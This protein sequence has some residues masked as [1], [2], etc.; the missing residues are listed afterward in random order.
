[1]INETISRTIDAIPI[2]R[3]GPDDLSSSKAFQN[4]PMHFH[5]R[6]Y[7]K[8]GPIYRTWFRDRMWVTL[9]GLDAN[10]FVWRNSK[11]WSYGTA[12]APFH[13]EM[14]LDHVTALD[15]KEHLA[16]RAILK[17]AVNQGPATR[18][19]PQ[20]LEIL[21]RDLKEQSEKDEPME[22][23]TYWAEVIIWIATHTHVR[24]KIPKEEVPRLARWEYQ[25]LRGL[26]LDDQR[27]SYVERQE[28]KELKANAYKWMGMIVDE[29]LNAPDK[30]DDNFTGVIEARAKK[31]GEL[32]RDNLMNDLYLIWLAGSDNTA[33][34]INWALLF[35]YQ[36][37]EWLEELRVELDA[38]DGKDVMAMAKMPRLKATIM[39]ANRIRPGQFALTKHAGEA[40]EFGGYS[41]PAGTDVMHAHVLAH[42]MEEFYPEPFEFKPS[43]FLETGKYIPK[44]EGT[45]GG[46]THICLGRNF[47]LF[48]GTLIVAH[49]LR[50]YDVLYEK[51]P[52]FEVR[53]TYTGGR[54]EEKIIAHLEPRKRP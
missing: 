46:G 43:R 35:T 34:L 13:E 11:L 40:F 31:I 37:P 47:S 51:K 16:K 26:F 44:T 38:W 39:E 36:N 45:F 20:F 10:E 4:D 8:C 15:G 14:G 7:R 17:P 9:A 25:M 23:M 6:A 48:Q 21:R 49:V 19:L 29:R 27:H 53:V 24:A 18:Y 22:L 1:M 5:V 2:Y 30:H 3:E 54:H 12:N 52:S 32:D 50:E 28:Y 42:F 41:I 33:N